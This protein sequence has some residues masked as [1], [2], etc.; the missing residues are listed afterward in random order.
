MIFFAVSTRES[1]PSEVMYIIPPQTI[2]N[3]ASIATSVR[4]QL[5]TVAIIVVGDAAVA[6][7]PGPA[8]PVLIEVRHPLILLLDSHP[9]N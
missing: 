9:E 2:A 5:I 8:I 1:L 6:S 7:P 4:S 3:M